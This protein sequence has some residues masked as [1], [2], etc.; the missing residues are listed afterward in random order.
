MSTLLHCP[1]FTSLARLT[2]IHASHMHTYNMICAVIYSYTQHFHMPGE[3]EY[4]IKI[5]P[6]IYINICNSSMANSIDVQLWFMVAKSAKRCI[7]KLWFAVN[8][9]FNS[10]NIMGAITIYTIYRIT[11]IQLERTMR[12][13]MCICVC[14]TMCM[15]A[16]HIIRICVLVYSTLFYAFFLFGFY[17]II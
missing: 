4:Q 16:E 15:D 6:S 17:S 10:T 11:Q 12:I 14:T 9:P 1:P 7:E 13:C 8:V 3:T 5:F 2:H